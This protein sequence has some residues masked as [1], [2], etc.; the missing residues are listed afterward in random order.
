MGQTHDSRMP[1][2]CP[3]SPIGSPLLLPRSPQHMNG[4]MSSSSISSPRTTS[5]LLMPLSNGAVP[6]HHLQQYAFYHDGFGS[7][8]WSLNSLYPNGSTYHDQK[9]DFFRAMQLGGPHAFRELIASENDILGMP[10]GR[11]AH[12]SDPWELY[13]EMPVLTDHVPQ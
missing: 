4:N 13:D 9:P 10:F 3:I 8:L 2:T 6:F 11:P 12:A 7:T 1:R 5:G